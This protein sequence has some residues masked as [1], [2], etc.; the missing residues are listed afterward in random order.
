MIVSFQQWQ[1]QWQ[2]IRHVY[3]NSLTTPN[4][5]SVATR[6]DKIPEGLAVSRSPRRHR[7]VL[8]M[9]RERVLTLKRLELPRSG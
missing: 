2:E 9:I 6:Y 5:R 8:V 3:N 7:D 1:W 4:W